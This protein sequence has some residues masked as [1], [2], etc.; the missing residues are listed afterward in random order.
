[1][2]TTN[3][4]I[5]GFTL[6][7]EWYPQSGIQL[8]WP[9]ADT[10]WNEYLDDIVETY[11]QMAEAIASRELLLIATPKPDEVRELLA[12]RL[13]ANLL[14]NIRVYQCQSND[15][16]ARDH[17]A[18]TLIRGEERRLLDFRFNG[19]G[20]KFPSD[21]DNA[22]TSR[23]FEHGAF[24]GERTDCDD[25]VLEGGSIESDGKGTILTT[26]CCLLAPH[27][28]Q[29]LGREE[30]ETILKQR[31]GAQRVL[32]IDYGSLNGDDTDG[33]IDTL[34]RFAPN[35]TLMFCGSGD[36]DGEQHDSLV[37]MKEQL[38]TLLTE[39]GKPF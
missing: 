17:G 14:D 32:W 19:W 25:F 9:H 26:S 29:P 22:I 2:M 30:I 38:G 13:P 12:K 10:D 33:H 39:D 27:R 6:P 35:D 34:V 1:M 16:W 4:I 28:N 5:E 37:R 31:L 11:L 18:I 15:T 23:L 21:L 36:D 8:T 20:E 24:N 7:A 3:N